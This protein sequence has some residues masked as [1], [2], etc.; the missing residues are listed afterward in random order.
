MEVLVNNSYSGDKVC[1]Y[2]QSRAL[3]LHNNDGEN[4][5]VI[6]VFLGVNDL[7]NG[8]TAADFAVNYP[9]MI[10]SIREK[11]PDAEIYLL[12]MLFYGGQVE[13][14]A[15]TIEAAAETYGCTFVD[16]RNDAGFTSS[17]VGSFMAD[18]YGI[19][20]GSQGMEMIANCVVNAMLAE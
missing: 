18:D 19:H 14:F 2:G 17:N 7:A 20:P 16:L 1:V 8:C 11:Y 6:A 5:D 15:S 13:A 9:A 12:S 3:Q 4:P 10:A